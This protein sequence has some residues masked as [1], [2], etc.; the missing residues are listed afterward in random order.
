MHECYDRF[1][2]VHGKYPFAETPAAAKNRNEDPR[3]KACGQTREQREIKTR[4]AQ[5]ESRI[6]GSSHQ[7]TSFKAAN[8]SEKNTRGQ[9]RA[10]E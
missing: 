5:C 8:H 3:D 2:P 4:K 1:F 6:A 7:S 9:D 10:S